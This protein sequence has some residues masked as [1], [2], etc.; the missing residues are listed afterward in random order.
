[1][2]R[3]TFIMLMTML[4]VTLSSVAWKSML[5]SDEVKVKQEKLGDKVVEL[6]NKDFTTMIIT[7]N[8]DGTFKIKVYRSR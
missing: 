6:A 4:L 3:K 1:M 8:V 5:T 7:K 2:T